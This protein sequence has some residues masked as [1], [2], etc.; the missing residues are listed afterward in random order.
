MTVHHVLL[1]VA[2]VCF[3]AEGI[4]SRSLIAAG[5]AFWVLSLLV[6]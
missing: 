2:L 4:L 6:V 3:A 1:I 5:L